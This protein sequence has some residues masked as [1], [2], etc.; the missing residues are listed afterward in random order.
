[1]PGPTVP[2]GGHLN[3]AV[4]TLLHGRRPHEPEVSWLLI[5]PHGDPGR[6]SVAYGG[7]VVEIIETHGTE[8]DL[9]LS[10]RGD[11]WGRVRISAA[12]A[13]EAAAVL[14]DWGNAPA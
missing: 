13:Q 8:V 6:A 3:G 11:E 9:I 5:F 1:M 2:D 10:V 14:L 4:P 7:A 12:R